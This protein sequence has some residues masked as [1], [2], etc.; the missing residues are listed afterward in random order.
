LRTS[1]QEYISSSGNA[2]A[3]LVQKLQKIR[4][5]LC[6]KNFTVC[7]LGGSTRFHRKFGK[8]KQIQAKWNTKLE[9]EIKYGSCFYVT[10]RKTP[11]IL[12]ADTPVTQ[13][14]SALARLTNRLAIVTAARHQS[15]TGSLVTTVAQVSQL[16]T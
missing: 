7:H 9:K 8:G 2:N 5:K 16:E 11:L 10:A 6:I 14:N 3:D 4:E 12:T 1:G 13:T 15:Q